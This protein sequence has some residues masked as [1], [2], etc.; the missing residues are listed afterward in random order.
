MAVGGDRGNSTRRRNFH[1]AITLLRTVGRGMH[2]AIRAASTIG[3]T[4]PVVVFVSLLVANLGAPT[5]ASARLPSAQA[6]AM[7]SAVGYGAG[8]DMAADPAG[9]YWTTTAAGALTTHTGATDFGSLA[10]THLNA[11]IVGMAATPDGQ[12]YWL[13]ASDGGI[14]SFGDAAFFGSTGGIRLNQP[15]V[16]MA[17]TPDG[18]GY[19]LVASDGGIFSFG[20]AAFFGS[21]GAIH[22]NQPIVGMAATPDGQGYWLVASDGGIFSFGDAAFFGSTGAIHLNQPIVAMTRHSGRRGLLARGE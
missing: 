8:R 22:L 13:V 7:R 3:V 1:D 5:T 9:G 17:A 4:L 19:W 18:Q 20:D 6:T 12:G 2:R 11:S 16:G 15:I 21:T 10:G 14:F